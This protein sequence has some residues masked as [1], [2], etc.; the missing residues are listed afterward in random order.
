MKD[1]NIRWSKANRR[2]RVE[3]VPSYDDSFLRKLYW[4]LQLTARKLGAVLSFL[5]TCDMLQI[6][7]DQEP[8]P[9]TVALVVRA[10]RGTPDPLV[11]EKRTDT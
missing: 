5:A 4:A 3:V 8:R 10:H 6:R 9:V 11:A 1:I 2:G 7:F